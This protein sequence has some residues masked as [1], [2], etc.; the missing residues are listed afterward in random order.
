[1]SLP[2]SRFLGRWNSPWHM[3]EQTQSWVTRLC[4]G[5]QLDKVG[6]LVRGKILK[7]ERRYIAFNTRSDIYIY[8]YKISFKKLK[9]NNS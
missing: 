8:I 3:A 9:E 5:M 4:Q 6:D 7:A 2:T 1:M